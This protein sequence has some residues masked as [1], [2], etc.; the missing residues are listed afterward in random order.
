MLKIEDTEVKFWDKH[1][2]QIVECGIKNGVFSCTRN[3]RTVFN[4]EIYKYND[5]NLV[6]NREPR[7]S[8]YYFNIAIYNEKDDKAWPLITVPAKFDIYVRRLEANLFIV[9]TDMPGSI[10]DIKQCNFCTIHENEKQDNVE[11]DYH[12][13]HGI[14]FMPDNNVL[15]S[16]SQIFGGH[17]IEESIVTSLVLY[18]PSGKLLKSLYEFSSNDKVHYNYEIDAE[19]KE[20][21]IS[22]TT[23]NK[24][25]KK[26][27]GFDEL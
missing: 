21:I 9:W 6:I 16:T 7:F 12:V 2:G 10:I 15:L 22:E 8:E 18:D 24:V 1:E 3:E 27:V 19:K 17:G 4:S 23:K 25:K 20:L 26:T 14:H 11:V 13:L 5:Y